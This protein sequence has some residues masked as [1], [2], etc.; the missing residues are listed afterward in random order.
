M[1]H[2]LCLALALCLS[3][4][5]L[6]C[7]APAAPT[8]PSTPTTPPTEPP[9]AP[10]TEP[11]TAPTATDGAESAPPTENHPREEGFPLLLGIQQEDEKVQM[12][13]L[14]WNIA[15]GRLSQPTPW[16]TVSCNNV[17]DALI[18]HWDGGST[19]QLYA[20]AEPIAADVHI[21]QPKTF[22]LP[23][24]RCGYATGEGT[25][26]RID[27][28]GAL[29][30]LPLPRDPGDVYDASK[31]P[32]EPYYATNDA[33]VGIAAFFVYD[34]D[35]EEGDVVYC[36]YPLN[37]PEQA[38]WHSV[39]IP[40]AYAVDAHVFWNGAYLDGTLYLAAMQGILAIDMDRAE[41]HVLDYSNAFA[42]IAALHPGATQYDGTYEDEIRISGCQDGILLAE[43]PQYLPNGEAYYYYA[44]LQNDKM[45]GFIEKDDDIFTIYD[46][47]G[48]VMGTDDS[49]QGKLAA[50]SIQF[51]RDD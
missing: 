13:L 7:A 45:I 27:S 49:Y 51:P 48:K 22:M 30:K 35:T 40:L 3:L 47:N 43:F 28:A 42:A 18:E 6:G 25:L 10:P 33:D 36:T 50:L 14:T 29:H 12:N 9:T 16:Y 23:Y 41:L 4:A 20:D 5:L 17:L 8:E 44:A 19:V 11:P 1:K 38:V 31:L 39:H 24:G 32:M 26:Y 15:D 46:G 21:G 37:A 2:W 34:S